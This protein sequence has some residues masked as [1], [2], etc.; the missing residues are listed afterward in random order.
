M[1][2]FKNIVKIMIKLEE[3]NGYLVILK[4]ILCR[5]INLK[6]LIGVFIK[7]RRLFLDLYRLFRNI[8]C[9]VVIL[10]NFMDM[11]LCLIK[12][13]N[14]GWFK[15]MEGLLWLLI[16]LLII[17]W[18]VVLLMMSSLFLIYKES[19]LLIRCQLEVLTSLL[20]KVFELYSQVIVTIHVF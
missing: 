10:F 19:C 8:Y 9:L 17:N 1:F 6:E 13:L 20:I 15:L 5:D 16:L 4:F 11:I 3:A 18:S 14:L 12:L 2:K 7:L